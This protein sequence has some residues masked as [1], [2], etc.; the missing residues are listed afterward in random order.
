MSISE[1]RLEEIHGK[2]IQVTET[3]IEL[4]EAVVQYIADKHCSTCEDG[5]CAL[6]NLVAA[7]EPEA[8]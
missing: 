6:C 4:L 3:E 2:H 1:D 8:L 5:E 7:C